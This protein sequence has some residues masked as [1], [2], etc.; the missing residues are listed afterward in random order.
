MLELHAFGPVD[1]RADGGDTRPVLAQPKRLALLL[2]LALAR[3]RRFQRR[4]TLVALLWPELD[5]HRARKALSQS[6]FFLRRMLPEPVVQV[7]GADEVGVDRSRIRCDVVEFERAAAE[8]RWADAVA[9]YRGGLLAGF[10]VSD[11]PAFET[12]LDDERERLRE[13]AAGA[14]WALARVRIEE[15]HLVDAERAGQRALRLVPTDESPV[16][17]FIRALAAA[18]DRA[19]ALRFFDKFATV[20]AEE[21]EV[22]PARETVAVME[23]VRA[24]TL[25]PAVEAQE[26]EAANQRGKPEEPGVEEESGSKTPDIDH[27]TRTLA[28]PGASERRAAR[29]IRRW[30]VEAAVAGAAILALVVVRANRG[31]TVPNRVAVLPFENLTGSTSLD[32]LGVA[33]ADWI[34]GGLAA[35]DTIH[36]VSLAT[37]RAALAEPNAGLDRPRWI[38]RRTGAGLVVTGSIVRLGDTLEL[39]SQLV[40]PVRGK[41]LDVFESARTPQAE[42]MRALGPIRRQIMGRLALRLGTPLRGLITVTDAHPPTYDAYL[43]YVAGVKLGFQHRFREAIRELDRA[44]AAD[45]N[46]T[47][48]A[49]WIASAFWNLGQLAREDSV[50]RGLEAHRAALAWPGTLDFLE[51]QVRGDNEGAYRIAREG[52]LRQPSS[53]GRLVL[54]EFALH[55]NRLREAVATLR[56]EPETGPPRSQWIGYHRALTA[57]LHELHDYGGELEA[58]TEAAER[59]PDRPE[60][61]FWQ[62]RALIGMGHVERA[63]AYA[64][65]GVT[66][67]AQGGPSP[68]RLLL[69]LAGELRFHGHPAA[70]DGT[71]RRALDWYHTNAGSTDYRYGMAQTR[72]SLGQ[73]DSAVVLLRQLVAEESRS[74]DYLGT[75]GL[76]LAA[77]GHAAEARRVDDR[78]AA[79]AN[80]YAHGRHLYW[81]AAIAAR[82]GEKERATALLRDGIAQGIYVDALYE[83]EDLQP[84]WDFLP[85][86][87]LLTPSD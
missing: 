10:H 84:L 37:V 81:R 38:A 22:A 35:I 27:P 55:T 83:N 64:D 61:S 57:A 60:P 67:G 47:A 65:R 36:P 20:L 78:L 16:R 2:Y 76:A 74:V 41:V 73:P 50:L 69:Q 56:T 12:W 59:F 28:P 48:P 53:E 46:F 33:A 58:A 5:E 8:R 72:L 75:L 82:L 71:L 66:R 14:A 30:A 19:A 24:G 45:S 43:A 39:R 13:L 52:Y 31:D 68:G 29:R 9:L 40:D 3:P 21:L 26:P 32:P 23:A 7:R 63:K 17:D 85:F 54:G 11:A 79:W 49:I 15:G 77:A 6:L 18:G 42:P 4:D 44:R 34:S 62:A 87:R 70:A 80:P 1:L 25:S 51:A 86:R